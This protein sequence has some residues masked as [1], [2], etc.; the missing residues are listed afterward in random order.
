MNKVLILLAVFALTLPLAA[1]AE[2]NTGSDVWLPTLVTETPQEGFALAIKLARMG[3]KS[4]QSDKEVLFREREK[5]SQDADSLI[6][7]SEVIAAY[8]QTVAAANNY[9]K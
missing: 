2:K 7:A 4:T 8:F 1:H 5:Y 3:V 9:W 6:H